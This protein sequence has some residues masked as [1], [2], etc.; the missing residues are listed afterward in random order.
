MRKQFRE[1][2]QKPSKRPRYFNPDMQCKIFTIL[3]AS[4]FISKPEWGG[5]HT[6]SVEKKPFESDKPIYT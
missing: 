1:R 4:N 2:L 3:R 5:N 6:E